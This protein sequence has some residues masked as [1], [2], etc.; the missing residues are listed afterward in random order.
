M[1]PASRPA[2]CLK[3][4]DR[5]HSDITEVCSRRLGSFGALAA[6]FAAVS[7]PCRLLRLLPRQ[8]S[9]DECRLRG[10]PGEVE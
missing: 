7:A 3:G 2:A 1:L 8:Q 5:R 4:V 6:A 10:Q 9:L